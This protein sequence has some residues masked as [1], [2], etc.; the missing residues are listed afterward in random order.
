MID[1]NEY[2]ERL[3]EEEG[4]EEQEREA[5]QRELFEAYVLRR[6]DHEPERR[7]LMRMYRD[8]HPLTGPRGLR[9]RLAAID[10]GYFG[11]AYLKHYFVRKSPQF[12][13]ELDV[14]WTK[15]VLKS[16]NPYREAAEISR[17][18]GSKSVVAAPRG[19]AKIHKFHIQGFPAC[20]IVPLQALYH[21]TFRFIG[22]GGRLLTDIKTELEENQDI[23]EDFWKAAGEGVEKQH[24]P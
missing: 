8:G 16:R 9:K 2:L 6:T 4:R 14:I 21:H 19:H 5:Y 15:G 23:R 13:E 7:E 12:H 17:M 22:P 18:D 11:R 10:L 1:I 20:C 24:Y 3:D